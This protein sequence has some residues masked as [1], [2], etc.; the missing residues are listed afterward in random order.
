M[1][2]TSCLPQDPPFLLFLNLRKDSS[3]LTKCPLF[4]PFHQTGVNLNC[5]VSACLVP[6]FWSVDN[7][8][9][10]LRSGLGKYYNFIESGIIFQW[11]SMNHVCDLIEIT[12]YFWLV[13]S[14]KDG[15]WL[16]M[17]IFWLCANSRGMNRHVFHYVKC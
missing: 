3:L 4:P 6:R 2:I 10:F 15:K 7:W 1:F 5:S 9:Y 12:I 11:S 17:F 13:Y 8:V 16:H 14:M